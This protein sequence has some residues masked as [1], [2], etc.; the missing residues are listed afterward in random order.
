MDRIPHE[1]P[2]IHPGTR[3]EVFNRFLSSWVRGFE[4]A[5]RRGVRYRLRRCSDGVVLP[6]EFGDQDL[7]RQPRQVRR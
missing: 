1:A 7:R 5:T 6:V 3:V 2:P 4:I